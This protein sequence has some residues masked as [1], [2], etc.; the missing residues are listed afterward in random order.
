MFSL[1]SVSSFI[2]VPSLLFKCQASISKFSFGFAFSSACVF[3]SA[4]FAPLATF[5]VFGLPRT[6]FSSP[7]TVIVMLSLV[8]F[9]VY[10]VL[11]LVAGNF[12][13]NTGSHFSKP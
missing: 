12:S 5:T 4:H 8:H 9:A 7:S 10:I 11:G 13:G 3:I 1:N 2:S 6:T